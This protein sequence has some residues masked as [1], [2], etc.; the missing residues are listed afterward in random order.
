MFII[1]IIIIIKHR[2]WKHF[3]DVAHDLHSSARQC[4]CVYVCE[5]MYVYSCVDVCDAFFFNL[6]FKVV[7]CIFQKAHPMYPLVLEVT[8]KNKLKTFKFNFAFNSSFYSF[9]RFVSHP[10]C[11]FIIYVA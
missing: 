11:V 5:Q 6:L 4:V 7:M 8:F 2:V 1:I 9:R 10:Y 3:I